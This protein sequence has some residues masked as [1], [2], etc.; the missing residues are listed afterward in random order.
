M[1]TN[2]GS[3]GSSSS[4]GFA[5]DTK[6]ASENKTMKALS[7]F[8]RPEFIN[9]IDEIITFNSLTEDNFADIAKIMLDEL[10]MALE[11][12]NI[13]FKYSDEAAKLIAKESYSYKYGARNMRR[14]IRSHVEDALAERIISDYE[15][16]ISIAS[17]S[18][19]DE[20]KLVV[21]CV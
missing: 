2:A 5:M 9:R 10:K 13:R 19:N 12:K 17:L 1:T 4:V 7:S 6:T 20:N 11:E 8:L 15:S 18:V 16:Q 14:Y 3:N 21:E